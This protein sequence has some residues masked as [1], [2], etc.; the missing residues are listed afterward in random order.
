MTIMT[1]GYSKEYLFM[2]MVIIFINII[3]MVIMVMV[4]IIHYGDIITI[5]ILWGYMGIL[6]TYSSHYGDIV[7]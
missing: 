7:L 2:I 3:L 4:I 1:I 5:G 6:I